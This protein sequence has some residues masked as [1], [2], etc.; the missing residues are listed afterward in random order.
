MINFKKL[1]ESL[2]DLKTQYNNSKPFPYIVIDNFCDPKIVNDIDSLPNPSKEKINKSRDYVF[3]KNKFE[4][5]DFKSF[6]NNFEMLYKDMT[7]ARFNNLISEIMGKK[8][9]VDP[10][11]YGGG[12]HQGGEGSFLDMH[13]DFNLHPQ[14]STWVRELN[15]LLYLNKDWQKEYGGELEIENLNNRGEIHKIEPVLNRCVIMLTK[16]FTLHGYKKISFPKGEYRR[17]IAAYAYS[18]DNDHNLNERSTQWFP[19][20]NNG[21]KKFL[22]KYWPELVKIKGAIFGK[23]T[24]NNK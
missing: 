23:G 19:Q 24:K 16:D 13:V 6:S 8:V 21:I 12:L 2:E 10:D 1:E 18:K 17:S 9:F 15:I 7:S 14:N 4:K 20:E 22:G 3:A 11:F 5:S